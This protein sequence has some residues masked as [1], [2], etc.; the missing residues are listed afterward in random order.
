MVHYKCIV[1]LLIFH[2]IVCSQE[3]TKNT[4]NLPSGF[5]WR[6]HNI[7]T[8]VK[9]QGN[10]GACGAFAAVG[11]F[12]ALIR[13]ETGVTVDISEQHIINCSPDWKSSG[14]SASNALKFMRLSG[15]VSEGSLPYESKRSDNVPG[16][17]SDYFLTENHDV[18]VANYPLE[19]RISMFKEAIYKYGP[20]ATNMNYYSDLNSYTGGVYTYNGTSPEIGGHWIVVVGWKDEPRIKNG[21]YW[22][23]RDSSGPDY[24]ENGYFRIAYGESGVDDYYFC[25]GIYKAEN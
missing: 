20:V 11:V 22:I 8:T 3:H 2:S 12:E 7:M 1:L 23:C 18:T 14:I 9:N 21:G 16:K 13:K 24:G 5:D 25:Y 6:Q 10:F 15:I 4:E 19:T 17:N